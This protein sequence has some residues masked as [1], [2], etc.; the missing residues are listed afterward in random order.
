MTKHQPRCLLALVLLFSLN[1]AAQTGT[2]W[3]AI[4]P[5][6]GVAPSSYQYVHASDEQLWLF[7][8]AGELH[9]SLDSGTTWERQVIKIPNLRQVYTVAITGNVWLVGGAG[10]LTRSTDGGNSWTPANEG[11]IRPPTRRTPPVYNLYTNGEV[12]YA[13]A[14]LISFAAAE[15]Y[16]VFVSFDKGLTWKLVTEWTFTQAAITPTGLYFYDSSSTL[17]FLKHGD[18]TANVVTTIPAE[19]AGDIHYAAGHLFVNNVVPQGPTF[20]RSGDGGQRW[21]SANTCVAA[22]CSPR[23]FA[24]TTNFHA[25]G[26][27]LFAFANRSCAAFGSDSE[28]VG[29]GSTDVGLTWRS[30]N[31]GDPGK[32][33]NRGSRIIGNQN[34]FFAWKV[35]WDNVGNGLW[36]KP[37]ESLPTL[38]PDLFMT[39]SAA[40]YRQYDT[41]RGSIVSGFGTNLSASTVAASTLPLPKNLGSVTVSIKD[42]QMIEHL[43][44]LFFVAP[45]QINYLIPQD[46]A[47]G[48]ATIT[49]RRDGVIVAQG[50]LTIYDA[51][52]ALFSLDATGSGF[53]ATLLLRIKANGQTSYDPIAQY[54]TALKRFV[55]IPIDPGATSDQLFLVLFGTGLKKPAAGYDY[56]FSSEWGKVVFVGDVPGL[57]G[58]QQANVQLIR[59]LL[60]HGVTS[61]GFRY[62]TS[63]AFTDGFCNPLTSNSLQLEFK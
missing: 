44:P 32:G 30:I 37:I 58:L 49:V 52:S 12:V 39:T 8:S 63:S 61:V 31:L 59:N 57:V 38:P 56:W 43:A 34:Y 27:Q 26:N 5:P 15:F 20:L 50:D 17:L 62:P 1:T 48:D 6:A 24:T 10:G 14:N 21:T 11:L 16:G 29:Y 36:R 54:D 33:P 45:Q 25:Q 18:T 7:T 22:R 19:V 9:H 53:P 35:S 46:I 23:D 47:T 3:E 28:T 41:A 42:S 4:A 51:G 40:S 60:P 55:A 13:T 2:G